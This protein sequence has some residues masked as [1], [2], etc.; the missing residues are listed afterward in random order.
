MLDST[1]V[2]IAL[3]TIGKD[4]G[5]GLSSLQWVINAYTLTLA[6]FLLLGGALGDRFGRRQRVPHRRRVVRGSLAAVRGC[7]M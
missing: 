5:A 3:P 4:F 2:N 1:V 6:G 7:S